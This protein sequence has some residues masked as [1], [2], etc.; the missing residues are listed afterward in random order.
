M[1][2]PTRENL[3]APYN[4]RLRSPAI[5]WAESACVKGDQSIANL[6]TMMQDE[7]GRLEQT[8]SRSLCME[9][10]SQALYHYGLGYP[11]SQVRNE[12]RQ[13]AVYWLRVFDLRG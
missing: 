2:S 4:P 5:G 7:P 10:E 9:Y 12:L 11:I 6:R 1:N 8:R 3:N 13:S